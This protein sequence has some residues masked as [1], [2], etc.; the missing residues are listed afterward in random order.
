MYSKNFNRKF[1]DKNKKY[2]RLKPK[3][4]K[5]HHF[6]KKWYGHFNNVEKIILFPKSI[7]GHLPYWHC[8]Q[9]LSDVKWWFLFLT[10]N[11]EA[12]YISTK[13]ADLFILVKKIQDF[14]PAHI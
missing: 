2:L 5:F 11:D 8:L 12:H 9:F 3:S 10:I 6:Q 14:H 1:S 7:R 4:S 13:R